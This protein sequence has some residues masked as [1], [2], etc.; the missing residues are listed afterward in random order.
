MQDCRDCNRNRLMY[1]KDKE[2]P[3]K[4]ALLQDSH[5]CTKYFQFDSTAYYQACTEQDNRCAICHDQRYDLEID[6]HHRDK[7]VRALLCPNGGCNLGFE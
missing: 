4:V 2:D 3:V 7:Y 1:L 6:H 5:L